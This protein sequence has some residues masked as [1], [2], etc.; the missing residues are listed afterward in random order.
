MAIEIWISS[1]TRVERDKGASS[2]LKMNVGMKKQV[3]LSVQNQIST[4]NM[5][6]NM[7]CQEGHIYVLLKTICVFEPFS[8]LSSH[9]YCMLKVTNCASNVYGSSGSPS[10]G[11]LSTP[12]LSYPLFVLRLLANSH[13]DPFFWDTQRV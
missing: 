2:V 1:G 5:A 13:P 10:W 12:V 3:Y 11:I 7:S 6:T 9:G 8:C 4:R